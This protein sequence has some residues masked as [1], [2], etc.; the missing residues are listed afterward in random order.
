MR[1]AWIILTGVL[2][3]LAIGAAVWL[4]RVPPEGRP[5]DEAAEPAGQGPALRVGLIPERDIFAQRARYRALADYLAERLNRPVELVTNNTYEG[6]LDDFAADRVDAAFLGSFV[7]VLAMDRHDV[8]VVLKP[9][10]PGGV[11]TYRGVILVRPDSAI[12]SIDDLG[13]CS[14]AMVKATT[15]GDLF[16]VFERRGGSKPGPPRTSGCRPTRRN[17][18]ACGFDAWRSAS[19]CRT[20]R[21]CFAERWPTRSGRSWPT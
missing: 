9:E 19:R 15:A 17:I 11:T 20:T 2:V 10:L 8:R 13:G 5:E 3:L 21:S 7:A 4:S 6:V 1:I 16:P 18:P 12:E 14:M